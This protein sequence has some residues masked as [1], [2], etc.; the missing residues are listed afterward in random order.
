[1]L[2]KHCFILIVLNIHWLVLNS[3]S[4]DAPSPST[5]LQRGV[6]KSSHQFF[7]FGKQKNAT[8]IVDGNNVRGIGKF[9][10]NPIKLQTLLKTFCNNYGITRCFIIWD[11]GRCKFSASESS[12]GNLEMIVLFSGISRRADDIMVKEGRHIV[13]TLCNGNWSSISFVTNDIGLRQ[14]LIKQ[15]IRL[16]LKNLR[17]LMMDSTRFVELLMQQQQCV[18]TEDHAQDIFCPIQ[19]TQNSLRNFASIQKLGYNSRREKTWERCVLAET[20]LQFYCQEP[21][22]N[23]TEF[24]IQYMRQLHEDRGYTNPNTI[25]NE[26]IAASFTVYGPS[27]LDKHQRRLLARYNKARQTGNL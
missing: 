25:D 11:H 5:R 17:P 10:W 13:D 4:I 8:L 24:S 22:L 16:S 1:M 9:Q 15:S 21:D 19:E 20:L 14:K 7:E 18:E 26:E 6:K 23:S 2:Y 3:F 27:R 12:G